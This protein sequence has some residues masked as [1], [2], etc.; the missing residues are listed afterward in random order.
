MGLSTPCLCS[1]S[2]SLS[3]MSSSPL[4]P[5]LLLQIFSYLSL[6]ELLLHAA[7]VCRAWHAICWDLI[8]RHRGLH[9]TLQTGN[10]KELSRDLLP[11]LRR[12]GHNRKLR[13]FSLGTL[14]T[15]N[16][17]YDSV[18]TWRTYYRRLSC[19]QLGQTLPSLRELD[20]SLQPCTMHLTRLD[21]LPHWCP[22]L[23][24][25][26]LSG[27]S[28]SRQLAL[29]LL[30]LTRLA[31]LRLDLFSLDRDALSLLSQL[32]QLRYFRSPHDDSLT[33]DIYQMLGDVS[34]Q[35]YQPNTLISNGLIRACAHLTRLESLH[36][37]GLM[38]EI[39]FLGY[40]LHSLTRLRELSLRLY[41]LPESA[42]PI[43]FSFLPLLPRLTQLHA[44]YSHYVPQ[45]TQLESLR[46]FWYFD[47]RDTPS[48]SPLS[49]LRRLTVVDGGCLPP[50]ERA[51]SDHIYQTLPRLESLQ[52]GR[53]VILPMKTWPIKKRKEP[54]PFCACEHCLDP[55]SD[56]C[57]CRH[58]MDPD[59]DYFVYG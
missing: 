13:H 23:T 53:S 36:L 33:P 4:P 38:S 50:V 30:S 20:I 24:Q 22:H 43:F 48:L 6:S 12:M 28:L 11:L 15:S 16:E 51:W 29:D 26:S 25:L 2:L 27:L 21:R 35:R 17:D 59:Y 1:L 47:Q 32:T 49:R 7:R 46:L 14:Q 44:A 37:F 45:L 57:V 55:S 41:G 52:L 34:G 42:G 39:P 9:L 3:E 40:G 31:S 19:A 54:P 58:C 10:P 8:C 56:L 5:E 18:W